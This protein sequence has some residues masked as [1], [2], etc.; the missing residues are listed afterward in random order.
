[1][2][3]PFRTLFSLMLLLVFTACTGQNKS[4][5]S[6]VSSTQEGIVGGPFENGEFMYYGMPENITSVDTSAAWDL[7]GQKLLIQGKIFKRDGKT[8]AP[9][10]IMY[11]YQTDT[12]GYYPNKEDLDPR[13]RRHGYIRGWVKSDADGNYAIYTVR[14]APYPNRNEPAHI[15]ISVKE[16]DIEKEYYLDELVFDDDRLLTTAKRKAMP[17]RGGSGVLRLFE[18][19]DLQ[20]AEHNVI[21]GLNIPYYP[22]T[23]NS[24]IDSGIKMGEDVLS[25]TPFHAWGPDKGSKTCPVCKYGKY[26]GILYFIGRHPD[27][28][29]IK[30]WLLYF[31]AESKKRKELLKVYLVYGNDIGYDK[32]IREK[33]LEALGTTLNIEQVALTFVPSFTN[34]DSEI[35]FLG[36]DKEV[37]ST[38]LI[39]KNRNVIE[40]Y[41]DLEAS[42]T[43]FER[44]TAR[45]NETSGTFSGFSLPNG[46]Y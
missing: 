46:M 32:S 12:A 20:I 17:N 7:K 37:E 1:M 22:N 5:I 25:F 40:K 6:K 34:S 44:I 31:E 13:V 45:L 4:S 8:P 10:V 39:Y 26:H 2:S 30:K 42:A 38:I 43:N 36:I 27:W 19:D 33:E 24:S 11:Y 15:H 23:E 9:G 21:L 14:P 3:K 29:E 16:P 28:T 35:D 18:H 41:I